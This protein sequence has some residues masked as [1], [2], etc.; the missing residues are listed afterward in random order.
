[1]ADG[2]EVAAVVTRVPADVAAV[3]DLDDLLAAVALARDLCGAGRSAT[4]ELRPGR[5]AVAVRAGG[6]T[7]LVASEPVGDPIAARLTCA[8][9]EPVRS[10]EEVVDCDDE[11][12][13]DG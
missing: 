9:A 11:A 2:R 13:G 7:V 8:G 4:V 6:A 3:V 1:V 10:D 12:E 5:D